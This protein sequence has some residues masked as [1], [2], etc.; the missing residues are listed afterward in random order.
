ME[1]ARELFEHE[2]RDMYDAENKL[3]NALKSMAGKV[4]D[5]RLQKAFE[6]HRTETEGQIQRLEQVFGMID[7]SP[8]REPCVGINGI[9][10][11]FTKFVKE[12]DPSEEIL[13]LFA[14]GAALKSEHYEISSYR[15]LIT[16]AGQL[17][18]ADAA[19]LLQQNLEEEEK[20]AKLVEGMAQD[21][22][23]KVSIG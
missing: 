3:V 15:S 23:S 16:L 18:L 8:R 11:E 6:T 10:E 20:T 22:G 14:T 9:I 12:E 1:T 17:G 5:Q 19:G 4:T 21:L 13:N 7:R 2:L